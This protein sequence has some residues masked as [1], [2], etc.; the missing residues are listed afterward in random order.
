MR[1][2][3]AA[4]DDVDGAAVSQDVVV[5]TASAPAACHAGAGSKRS[6]AVELCSELPA[7]SPATRRDARWKERAQ[8]H[9]ERA[10]T[11][12]DPVAHLVAAPAVSAGDPSASYGLETLAVE[13][14]SGARVDTPWV[15]RK[16]PLH[17]NVSGGAQLLFART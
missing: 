7:V 1:A 11:S 5:S 12:A 17:R 3:R 14:E 8:A 13:T 6:C 9:A 16:D 15:A 4:R 2:I 10:A